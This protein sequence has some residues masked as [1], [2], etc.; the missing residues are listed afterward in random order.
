MSARFGRTIPRRLHLTAI[1]NPSLRSDFQVRHDIAIGRTVAA[2]EDDSPGV[3]GVI[4]AAA[5]PG[6]PGV[7]GVA[8]SELF[9]F[10]T[11]QLGCGNVQGK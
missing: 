5:A 6:A 4:G 8:K 2:T 11:L 3:P 7:T 10:S 9:G 1:V